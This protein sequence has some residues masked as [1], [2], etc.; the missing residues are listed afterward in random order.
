M[1]DPNTRIRKRDRYDVT[2]LRPTMFFPEK[3]SVWAHNKTDAAD[4]IRGEFPGC[5]IQK[6]HKRK[7]RR[8]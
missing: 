5:E 8:A 7:N 4:Y 3:I 2:M 1:K 6:V